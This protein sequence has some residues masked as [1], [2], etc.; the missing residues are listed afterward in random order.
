MSYS[1][2]VQLACDGRAE[3]GE[4]PC[5]RKNGWFPSLDAARRDAKLAGWAIGLRDPAGSGRKLDLCSV[6]VRSGQAVLP[7][8]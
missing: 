6:C 2:G 8:G 7:V 5:G 4:D 3:G 1:T